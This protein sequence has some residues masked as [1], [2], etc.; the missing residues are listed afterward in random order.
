MSRGE[1]EEKKGGKGL[2]GEIVVL[3]TVEVQFYMSKPGAISSGF[4]EEIKACIRAYLLSYQIHTQRK[5]LY[6]K[7][8]ISPLSFDFA[9][10]L[11]RMRRKSKGRR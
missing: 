11:P 10:L 9:Q 8:C 5:Y 1:K 3:V 2:R 6:P 7:I 4:G